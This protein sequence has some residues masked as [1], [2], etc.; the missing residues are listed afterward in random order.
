M[1]MLL[2]KH[3]HSLKSLTF[4]PN[5]GIMCTCINCPKFTAK[6]YIKTLLTVYT[7]V[8]RQI[9]IKTKQHCWHWNDDRYTNDRQNSLF[10]LKYNWNFPRRRVHFYTFRGHRLFYFKE[11]LY[12]SGDRF[13]WKLIKWHSM[14]HLSGSLLFAK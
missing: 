7:P 5:K 1:Y 4:L 6:I 9:Y 14:W 11:M 13:L 3:N 2:I 10:G 8:L 12:F